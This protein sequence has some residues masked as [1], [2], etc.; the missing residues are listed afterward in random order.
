MG[1]PE[2]SDVLNGVDDDYYYENGVVVKDKGLVLFEGDYYYVIY[3]GKIKKDGDRV[4]T[5]EKANGLLP[6]GKYHFGTDGKMEYR[7][8]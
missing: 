8:N 4:V 7:V 1:L 6:A 2:P 5:E 3:N